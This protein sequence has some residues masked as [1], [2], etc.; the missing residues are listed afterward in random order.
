MFKVA[1]IG[2]GYW[3]P[4][5]ARNIQ[6]SNNFKIKFIVDKS[7]KNLNNAKKDFPL[8]KLLKS[9]KSIDYKKVNL[10]VISTPTITCH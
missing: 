2:Y 4:K 8:C 7:T 6:N 1:I 9:Y 5:L 10:V 3:G